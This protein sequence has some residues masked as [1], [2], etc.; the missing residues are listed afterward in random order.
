MTLKFR[1]GAGLGIM[2]EIEPGAAMRWRPQRARFFP[3]FAACCFWLAAF[4]PLTAWCDSGIFRKEG[5]AY[6]AGA[7]GAREDGQGEALPAAL[8]PYMPGAPLNEL[9][10]L[11]SAAAWRQ[12]RDEAD[13]ALDIPGLPAWDRGWI[14]VYRAWGALGENDLTAAGNDAAA[15]R[16]LMPHALQPVLLQCIVQ[17]RQGGALEAESRLKE[18]TQRGEPHSEEHAAMAA[19][20]QANGDWMSAGHWYGEALN[21]A[22]NSARLNA[23]MAV[24]LWRL[25]EARKALDFMSR[26]VR[27]SPGNADFYNERGMMFL[28][29]GEA[30]LALADF[31]AALALDGRHCGA[32]LNRGNLFFYAGRPALA[33]GDFSLGLR[34]YPHDSGLLTGRARV[35]AAQGRY[36]EAQRDLE[37][38]L[39][40]SGEDVQALIVFAWFLATCPDSRYWNG[41]LAVELVQAAMANDKAGE[42]G[43]YDTLAAARAR[44]GEFKEA[45][46]AQDQALLKGREQGAPPDVLEEWGQ[47][48]RLYLK[49]EAYAQA[50]R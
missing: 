10:R 16:P 42:A 38:A 14:Y 6:P 45:V 49:G 3:L 34:V 8:H 44:A 46:A 27:L 4:L 37:T 23:S 28:N 15:A 35:Y 11:E 2:H 1:P 50:A 7:V 24:V 12:L 13:R 33:E 39:G 18:R 5:A 26:A 19:F 22:P 29:L 48:L 47:R 36:D 20:Y 43:L 17:A 25:G 32:L 21:L 9:A 40:L 41:P 30:N 31:N